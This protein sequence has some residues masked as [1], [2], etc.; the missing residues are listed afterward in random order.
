MA[1][2]TKMLSHISS[3]GANIS[4]G[5]AVYVQRQIWAVPLEKM[6]G[7]NDDPTRDWIHVYALPRQLVKGYA[8]LLDGRITRWDLGDFP[9]KAG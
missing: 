9:Y 8:L 5:T 7:M 2:A 4:T 3:Q 6:N 1:T